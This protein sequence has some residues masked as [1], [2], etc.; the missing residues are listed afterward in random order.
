MI[1]KWKTQN[2]RAEIHRVECTRETAA[3]VWFMET[4]FRVCGVAEP[5]ETK[6]SKVG[7][8]AYGSCTYH[9]TWEDAHKYLM[10]CA[11]RKVESARG[12]LQLA[13]AFEGNVKGL[14]K[15]VAA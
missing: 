13:H 2:G 7:G 12:G 5:V 3:S 15:A 10:A 6:A 4:P 14:K 11:A 1:E 9:D 8:D